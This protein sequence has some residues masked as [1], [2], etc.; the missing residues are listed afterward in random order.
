MPQVKALGLK[1]FRLGEDLRNET[2]HYGGHNIFL[3]GG[4]Y[5]NAHLFVIFQFCRVTSY[6]GATMYVL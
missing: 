2:L 6:N 1:Y 3:K 4:Y 5:K